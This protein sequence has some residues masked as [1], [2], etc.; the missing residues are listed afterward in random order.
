MRHAL[1][2]IAVR[3]P[4]KTGDVDQARS[5]CAVFELQSRVVVCVLTKENADTRYGIENDAHLMMARMGQ[6]IVQ[7]WPRKANPQ[8]RGPKR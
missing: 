6:A 2:L 3:A 5:E 4:H 8:G 7:A 1:S